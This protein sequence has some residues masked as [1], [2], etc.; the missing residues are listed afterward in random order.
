MQMRIAETQPARPRAGRT[1]L[2]VLPARALPSRFRAGGT[3]LPF[4]RVFLVD[5][6]LLAASHGE[7]FIQMNERHKLGNDGAGLCMDC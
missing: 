5:P 4:G 3:S 6:S 1:S 2:L 7:A